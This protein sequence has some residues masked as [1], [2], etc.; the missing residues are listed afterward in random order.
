MNTLIVGQAGREGILAE[1]MAEQSVLHAVVEHPNPTVVRAAEG[2]GGAWTQGGTCDPE[3]VVKFARANA[4]ELAMVS[5]DDPLE[6]GVVDALRAAGI[7]TVGPT[8]AGA[9]IEWSKSFARKLLDE[10]VPSANPLAQLVTSSADVD[11][12]LKTFGGM[13]LAVKPVGLTGGKGVKLMGPHL[14]SYEDARRYALEVLDGRVRGGSVLLEERMEGL[15]FTIQAITDGETIVYPPATYDYPYRCDGDTGPGTGGMG[16]FSVETNLLPGLAQA[17]YDSAC[18]IIERV[19]HRL[20][21]MGRSFSGVLNAGFFA[22]E[23][24]VKVVEFNARFGDPEC[25]NILS[26]LD[27]NWIETMEA[28]VA[29]TLRPEHVSLRREATAV[30]YLVSPEYA[31]RPGQPTQYQFDVDVARER[32]CRAYFHT[33]VSLG[34]NAYRTVGPGRAVGLTATGETI[35]DARATVMDAIPHALSGPLEWRRDIG[36]SDYIG[37]FLLRGSGP[38]VPIAAY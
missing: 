14:D 5:A 36:S 20:D 27:G 6:A 3:A 24:G 10:L 26:L 19:I 23:S 11:R 25:L 38:Q 16:S 21:D 17:D 32:G 34:G 18:S 29:R 9:E 1:K 8:R 30:V 28:I 4:V 35:D 22:S 13:P 15:E 37:E 7:R 31:L 33:S 2:S 12:A